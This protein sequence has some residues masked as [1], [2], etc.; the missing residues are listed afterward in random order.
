MLAEYGV[1]ISRS[2][3]ELAKKA[4][5]DSN[6]MKAI[7]AVTMF[8]LPGTFVAVSIHI[9]VTAKANCQ[10]ISVTI[11]HADVLMAC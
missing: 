5:R 3:E 8:F 4:V 2:S 11:C 9:L 1:N 6:S 7:A 10:A